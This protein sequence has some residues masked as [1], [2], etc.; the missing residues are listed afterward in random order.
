[1]NEDEYIDLPV[2]TVWLYDFIQW[3]GGGVITVDIPPLNGGNPPPAE[4]DG[5][6]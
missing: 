3:H 4:A 5:G 6:S 2:E 1:M